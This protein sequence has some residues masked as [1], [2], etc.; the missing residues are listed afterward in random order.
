MRKDSYKCWLIL[1]YD[2]QGKKNYDY[3]G[4][5]CLT[6]FKGIENMWTQFMF[7]LSVYLLAPFANYK[8][9]LNQIDSKNQSLH[10]WL[11]YQL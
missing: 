2:C 11:Y 7:R 9:N 4:L 5:Y 8:S 3:Q 10:L 1:P 6:A